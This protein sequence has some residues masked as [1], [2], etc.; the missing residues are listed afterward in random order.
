MNCGRQTPLSVKV[1]V[2]SLRGCDGVERNKKQLT[3]VKHYA[4]PID[5]LPATTN[6]IER[7]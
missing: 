7:E 1:M 5:Q 3:L 4:K 2:E 6:M